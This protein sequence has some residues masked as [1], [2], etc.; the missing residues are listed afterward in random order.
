MQLN[1]VTIKI[2]EVA[3]NKKNYETNITHLKEEDFE[4]NNKLKALRQA[5]SDQNSL[6][7]AQLQNRQAIVER[8]RA[9]VP[10][11]CHPV[12]ECNWLRSC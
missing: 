8:D 5:A 4:H 10:C 1:T 2:A 11:R 9:E 7:K 12:A 3:E 6:R